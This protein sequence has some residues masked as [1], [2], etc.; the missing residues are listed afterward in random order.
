VVAR[1]VDRHVA[2]KEEFDRRQARVVAAARAM[3]EGGGPCLPPSEAWDRAFLD[4]LLR[5]DLTAFDAYTDTAIDR[6]AGFGAHEVRTW[7]AAAAAMHAAGPFEMTLSYYRIVPEWITGMA[8]ARGT[9]V[10]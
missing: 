8:V 5:K 2:S 7:V 3:V 9:A 6:E 1:L 10:A 4:R